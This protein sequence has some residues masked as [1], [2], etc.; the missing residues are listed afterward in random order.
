[1][2][3][4]FWLAIFEAAYNTPT[5][6]DREGR[7]QTTRRD[8]RRSAASDRSKGCLRPKS[9]GKSEKE[10]VAWGAAEPVGSRRVH[11]RAVPLPRAE[12]RQEI[13]RQRKTSLRS[14]PRQTPPREGEVRT[15]KD[16][17]QVRHCEAG[18]PSRRTPHGA[19]SSSRERLSKRNPRRRKNTAL[20]AATATASSRLFPN[21]R[22][23]PT[24]EKCLPSSVTM[25]PEW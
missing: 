11:N 24:T 12:S 1:M 5:A 6:C 22:R 16:A 9:K 25:G 13:S 2:R 4:W 8:E 21:R 7:N 19:S 23:W 14:L 20:T 17:K 10:R 18:G 15:P 3:N